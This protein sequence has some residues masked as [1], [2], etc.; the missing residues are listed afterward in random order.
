MEE[1][2]EEMIEEKIEETVEETTD[3]NKETP[4]AAT[5]DDLSEELEASYKAAEEEGAEDSE[6]MDPVW[7]TLTGYLK[8]KTV[9]NVKIGGIVNAGVIAYVENVRG[10]IPA[11]RLSL[12]H[13]E[14]LN[15]W[16]HKKIRVRVITAEPTK[17]R[18]GLSAREILRDEARAKA[19]DERKA[20][21]EQ[22]SVGDVMEGTVETL[23]DYGAFIRLENGLS[24]LVHVS[25]ISDRRVT[26][27]DKVL[28]EGETVKVKVIAIKDGK[29]SLSM[30]ALLEKTSDEGDHNRD[31][32]LPKSESISTNLGSLLANLKL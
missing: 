20:A 8:D 21:M 1:K 32:K 12:E 29:L 7:A 23:K 15:E 18:L 10:F 16:L 13:V 26:S 22:T 11:S 27:P 19:A 17:T 31:Y 3:E 5:M 14:D 24:G 30:K 28:K 9:L 6:D 4:E 2:M 25:Q